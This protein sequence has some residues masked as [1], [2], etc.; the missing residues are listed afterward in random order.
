[1]ENATN[2]ASIVCKSKGIKCCKA[3]RASDGYVRILPVTAI[4]ADCCTLYSWL[5]TNCL[6]VVVHH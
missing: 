4:Y 1:M 2:A 5:V 6:L 3:L